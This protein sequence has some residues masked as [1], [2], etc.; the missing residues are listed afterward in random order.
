LTAGVKPDI[1]E[2]YLIMRKRYM[3]IDVIATALSRFLPYKKP[4]Y[5]HLSDEDYITILSWCED[6]NPEDVYYTAWNASPMDIAQ[7]WEKW[8]NNM[9]PLPGPVRYE[10]R[11]GLEIHEKKGNLRA[12]RS[13]AFVY[14][15]FEKWSKRFLWG[16]LLFLIYY[17]YF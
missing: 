12:L 10:L 16:S 17:L 5:D 14:E 7:D 4:A 9:T 3:F 1:L 13:Y 15:F 11:R 8:S 2:V 6:W